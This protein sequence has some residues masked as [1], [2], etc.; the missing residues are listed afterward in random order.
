MF[1]PHGEILGLDPLQVACEGRFTAFVSADQRDRALEIL[2]SYDPKACEIGHVTDKND[3]RVL[4]KTAVGVQR[5]LDMS[6]GEQLPRILL[7]LRISGSPSF[8]HDQPPLGVRFR[9]SASGLRFHCPVLH[10][11]KP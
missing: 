1:E 10:P 8:F 11:G 5:I 4:L 6:S 9:A 7:I 2:R 3:G